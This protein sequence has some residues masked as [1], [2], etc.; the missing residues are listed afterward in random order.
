MSTA[1]AIAERL[2]NIRALVM[3]DQVDRA[4]KLLLDLIPADH[5]EARNEAILLSAR[6]TNLETERRQLGGSAETDLTLRRLRLDLLQFV[7][8]LEDKA[9][10]NLPT[11]TGSQP[12]HKGQHSKFAQARIDHLVGRERQL[13][14]GRRIGDLA[15]AINDIF[16]SRPGFVLS[17][18]T[19]SLAVG[20]LVAIVGPNGSGKTTLLKLAADLLAPDKGNIHIGYLPLGSSHYRIKTTISYISQQAEP[21]RGSLL[22]NLRFEAAING[23]RGERNDEE[24]DFVIHR[25]RL[26]RYLAHGWAQLSAGYQTR[27]ELAR[28][29]LR[30]PHVVIMD[31]P[32]AH[33]DFRAQEQFLQDIFDIS[34]SPTRPVATIISSQHLPEVESFSHRIIV[35]NDGRVVYSGDRQKISRHFGSRCFE[36]TCSCTEDE[37]VRLLAPLGVTLEKGAISWIIRAPTTVQA[38]DILRCLVNSDIDVELFR[39]VTNSTRRFFS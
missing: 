20:E 25:L 31:E 36:V 33:L 13:H 19:F 6:V 5:R 14:A 30:E 1:D 23:K 3:R 11:G 18:D 34:T 4:T 15:I 9:K 10:D 8:R 37:F 7:D 39:D 24:V 26:E 2:E 38:R 21:W 12:I 29:L 32:L 27:F 17:I 28:A 22:D 35:L 16:L